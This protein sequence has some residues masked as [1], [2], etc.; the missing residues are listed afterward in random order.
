MKNISEL[1]LPEYPDF[2]RKRSWTPQE[3]VAIRAYGAACVAFLF[4]S[5][6]WVGCGD[7]DCSFPCN[8]G[9]ARCI[10][11]PLERTGNEP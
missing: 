2:M 11:L 4:A 7:C 3:E 9:E 6:T 8:N 10:R 1:P 5:N